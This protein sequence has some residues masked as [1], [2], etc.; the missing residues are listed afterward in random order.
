MHDPT[1]VVHGGVKFER[2][3]GSRDPSSGLSYLSVAYSEKL[4]SYS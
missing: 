1:V 3:Y 2:C 4:L